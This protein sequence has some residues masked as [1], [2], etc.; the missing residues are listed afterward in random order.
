MD[1]AAGTAKG[2]DIFGAS[3]TLAFPAGEQTASV[4]IVVRGDDL[5]EPNETFSVGLSSPVGATLAD[6]SGTGRIVS[7]EGPRTIAIGD[8]TVLE[9][10]AN[11]TVDAVF[12]LTLSTPVQ[13]GE[14]VT[15]KYDTADGTAVA[16]SDYTARSGTATF[17]VNTST[18]NLS[19]AVRGDVT[20]EAAER[21]ALNLGSPVGAVLADTAGLGTIR[22]DDGTTSAAPAPALSIGDGWVVEGAAGETRSAT[23]RVTASRI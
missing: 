5:P 16:G 8:T 17:P 7:D 6:A 1:T 22:N 18:L 14:T 11:T 12:T 20:V 23:F 3:G 19:V 13:S 15:V 21:F 9:G 10:K 4:T 2:T